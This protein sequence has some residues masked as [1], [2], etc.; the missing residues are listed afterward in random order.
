MVRSRKLSFVY[1]TYKKF[2]SAALSS[3]YRNATQLGVAP[4]LFANSQN[5]KINQERKFIKI[6]RDRVQAVNI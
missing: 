6:Q 4:F 1:Y 2:S 3:V 5:D